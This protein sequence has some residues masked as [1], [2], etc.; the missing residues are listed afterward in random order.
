MRRSARSWLAVVALALLAAGRLDAAAQ[1]SGAGSPPLTDDEEASLEAIR[2]FVHATAD[3]Y[4][5]L[6]PLQVSVAPW[7]GTEALPQYAGAPAVYTGGSLYLSRRLL[8]ASNRDLVIA[9]AL[10]YE[11][12][13]T[14]SKATTLAE[15]DRERAALSLESNARAVD[16]LV[17]VGGVTEEEA[18]EGMYA[19]LLGIHRARGAGGRPSPPGGVSAC[20]EIA[21]LLRRRPAVRERFAGR[22]C[23]PP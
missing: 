13:R 6:A 20:D 19:W 9:K 14:P 15:R 23:A 16:I 1:G 7:V 18:I 10:A 2:D 21:D 11:M 17:E 22:E 5:M 8:R 12:L 3:R 4:R